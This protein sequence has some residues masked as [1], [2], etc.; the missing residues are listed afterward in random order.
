MK[1]WVNL[2]F[3]SM[4]ITFRFFGATSNLISQ[5]RFYQAE[6]NEANFAGR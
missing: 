4:L 6:T 1:P 2:Y 3:M 5:M